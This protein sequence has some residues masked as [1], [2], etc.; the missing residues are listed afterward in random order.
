MSRFTA[1]LPAMMGLRWMEVKCE[2]EYNS[3]LDARRCHFRRQSTERGPAGIRHR[4]R[5][6]TSH[7][8]DS[9]RIRH[10]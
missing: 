1:V 2:C 5:S 4:T 7:Y 8:R 6:I 9:A 10:T 3:D